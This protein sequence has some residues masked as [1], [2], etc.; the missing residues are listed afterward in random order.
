MVT[1]LAAPASVGQRLLWMVQ[2]H[3]SQTTTLSCPLLCR[4][5]GPLDVARLAAAIDALV[6]R[7]EA[8][9][10]TFAGRGHQLT[11][12]IGDPAP[13]RPRTVAATEASLPDEVARE[14]GTPLDPHEEPVRATLWRLTAGDHLL[15][16]NMHHLV[17]DA[18][19]CGVL[20]RELRALYSGAPVGALGPAPWQYR[21]FVTWQEELLAGDGLA[22]Q[23]QYWLRRL[24]GARTVALP[25]P[26]AAPAPAGPAGVAR[27]DIPPAVTAAI[28]ELARARG[29]TPFTVLLAT[30]YARLAHL[31]GQ[32]DLVVASLFANRVRPPARGTVGFLANMV[33]LRG[34]VPAGASFAELVSQAHGTVVGAF[35]H[36]EL[37]FQLLPP[38]TVTAAGGARP[39]DVVFQVMTD[40][41]HRGAAGGV[42]FELLVPEGIGSRFRFELT[43]VPVADGLRALLFYATDRVDPV[44]AERFVADYAA[45]A[46][47]AAAHPNAPLP[48]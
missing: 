36:Q 6:G 28:R 41:P 29:T 20:F 37:P 25:G 27:A 17:T 40:T 30:F 43:V 24:D 32:R 10:T 12:I 2:R 23:R 48:R 4:M 34:A 26:A 21:E 45:A 5:R 19:S 44:T 22:R 42:D 13:L 15:C 8:L 39:D 18:W 16:L 11:Q 47:A 7:H 9:R 38:D 35:A 3:R 46:E 33:L 14:L 1:G 31:T